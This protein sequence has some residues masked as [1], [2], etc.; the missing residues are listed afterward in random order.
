MGICYLNK[1]SIVGELSRLRGALLG[2]PI[3]FLE[4][5]FPYT[6]LWLR[7]AR[8]H[9][10][11]L[12][13]DREFLKALLSRSTPQ[14]T[15][16]RLFELCRYIAV[17]AALYRFFVISLGEFGIKLITIEGA[18]TERWMSVASLASLGAALVLFITVE[19]FAAC[20]RFSSFAD[21]ER[22]THWVRR[23]FVCEMIAGTL[24]YTATR[25]PYSDVGYFFVLPLAWAAEFLPFRSALRRLRS[26]PICILAS[27]LASNVFA[28][29]SAVP[30]LVL[31]LNIALVR[32]IFIAVVILVF[33]YGRRIANARQSVLNSLLDAIPEGLAIVS[34]K[35]AKICWAN[36]V[37]NDEYCLSGQ[38]DGSVVYAGYKAFDESKGVPQV[39]VRDSQDPSFGSGGFPK[40]DIYRAPMSIDKD[41]VAAVEVVRDV[42]RR[43]VIASVTN[44]LQCACT[45]EDVFAAVVAAI[46][47]LG[48][49]RCRVYWLS[50]DGSEFIGRHSFGMDEVSF[51]GFRLPRFG[52]PYSEQTLA[53]NIPR[54]YPAPKTDE[55][56]QSLKKDPNLPWI[57][58][59]IKLRGDLYGKISIDNKGHQKDERCKL[60]AELAE[61]AG[62]KYRDYLL[63]LHNISVQAALAI[64]RIQSYNERADFLAAYVHFCIRQLSL[65]P[66]SAGCLV[67]G[68]RKE[69]DERSRS[70]Y[71]HICGIAHLLSQHGTMVLS[72]AD[73]ERFPNDIVYFQ[74][75]TVEVVLLVKEVVGWF[76]FIAEVQNI[77][78]EIEPEQL[79][80][81]LDINATT[82]ILF[83]LINNAF[84]ALNQTESGQR[85][86]L[87]SVLV[88]HLDDQRL[89]ISIRDNGP[90][91]DESSVSTLFQR[92]PLRTGSYKL[93]IG[94]IAARELA[95]LHGGDITL[96]SNIPYDSVEFVCTLSQRTR[97]KQV[98]VNV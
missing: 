79:G 88:R 39:V 96:R 16:W 54:V 41:V 18:R 62:R 44:D 90:G 26:L 1:Q 35:D 27:A 9:D 55:F 86:R 76:K 34:K 64:N 8:L 36:R 91:L 63:V 4:Q 85:P 87:I 31:L 65:L 71:T 25:N 57:E 58:V 21:G 22:R 78:V 43:E 13:I 20:R 30:L 19:V 95:R 82:Q 7:A 29:R 59:P 38:L 37:M 40:Y 10:R 60:L 89:E 32:T 72:W 68:D 45:E 70:V 98:P 56:C 17:F 42:T 6:R 53:S 75:E 92:K 83:A 5:Y 80:A 93:G 69:V 12:A 84:D 61:D 28:E 11:D 52:E 73:A 97:T 33:L 51:R 94:L 48:Y 81:E 23:V 67:A 47:N 77:I 74:P 50:S 49:K 24:L 46:A 3:S 2:S 14:I 66:A 15:A